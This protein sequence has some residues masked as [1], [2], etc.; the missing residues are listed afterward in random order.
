MRYLIDISYDGTNYNGWQR[1]NN[2]KTTVQQ[3]IEDVLSTISNENI[4]LAGC[5]RTDTGVH[6]INYIAHFDMVLPIDDIQLLIYR[7]NQILNSDIVVHSV[8]QVSEGFHA[9][10]DALSRSYSYYVSVDKN[11]FQSQFSYYYKYK[12]ELDLEALNN[13]ANLLIGKHNFNTF[14]KSGSDANNTFCEVSSCQWTF[15]EIK[16]QYVFNITSNRFLRGMIRL[17]VGACLNVER[18]K[19]TIAEIEY[20]LISGERLKLDWSVPANGLFLKNIV[21]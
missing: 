21:Y 7:V 16:N 2:T 6:A 11:P 14:C 5:G 8:K 19:L 10:F 17:I 13:C 12:N 3:S 9:R 20:G 4:V 18:Q 15:D 1:Q